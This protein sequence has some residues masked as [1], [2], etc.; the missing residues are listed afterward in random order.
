M[1]ACSIMD[2]LAD[3]HFGNDIAEMSSSIDLIDQFVAIGTSKGLYVSSPSVQA[4]SAQQTIF[5]VNG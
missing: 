2:S 1:I 4:S 5:D 3:P